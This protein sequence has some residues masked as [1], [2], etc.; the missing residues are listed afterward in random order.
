[1]NE[2]ACECRFGEE[3]GCLTGSV[4][5]GQISHALKCRQMSYS[6]KADA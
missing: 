1:M 4:I 5:F 2:F 6:L 3:S